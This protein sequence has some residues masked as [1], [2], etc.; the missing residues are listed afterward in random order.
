LLNVQILR[1][2]VHI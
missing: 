1:K 2:A